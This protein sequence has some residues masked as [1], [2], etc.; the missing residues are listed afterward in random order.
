MLAACTATFLYLTCLVAPVY[1][2]VHLTRPIVPG[3]TVRAIPRDMIHKRAAATS[4]TKIGIWTQSLKRIGSRAGKRQ[5]EIDVI[6]QQTATTTTTGPIRSDE[7]KSEN[8]TIRHTYG[9][10]LKRG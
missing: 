10:V 2:R 9:D 6:R 8:P 1:R 7:A 5:V 3:I 4:R